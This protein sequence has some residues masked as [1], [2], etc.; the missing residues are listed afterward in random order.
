[1]E[2]YI[3]DGK[4]GVI[5]SPGYGTGFYTGGAPLE[6]V[7]S[8]PLIT[9]I[10]NRDLYGVYKILKEKHNFYFMDLFNLDVK[11]IPQGSRF[12]ITEYDGSESIEILNEKKWLIA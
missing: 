6:A 9:M 2:K 12:K 5:I 3:K 11:W 10:Q 1:M 8:P 4:V 7:F